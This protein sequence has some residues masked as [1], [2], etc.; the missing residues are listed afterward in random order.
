MAP[1]LW[2]VPSRNNITGARFRRY[3]IGYNEVH[4]RT[5]SPPPPQAV[6]RGLEPFP[7]RTPWKRMLDKAVLG[8]GVIGPLASIPQVLKIYLTRMRRA[9]RHIVGHLG[10][11]RYSWIAYGLVIAS[12][13]LSLPTRCGLRELAHFHRGTDVRDRF[14]L[15]GVS[16]P[17]VAGRLQGIESA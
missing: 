7:A 8:V 3:F 14:A 5:S 1:A 2:R 10:T 17:Q 11:A 6:S 4:E 12:G 13:L 15:G 16:K 9:C